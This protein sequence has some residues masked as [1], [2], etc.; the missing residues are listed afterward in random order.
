MIFRRLVTAEIDKGPFLNYVRKIV[1][2]ILVIPA[3][4]FRVAASCPIEFVTV[5]LKLYREPPS[6]VFA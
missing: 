3:V 6:S 1:K 2:L 4:T 5:S